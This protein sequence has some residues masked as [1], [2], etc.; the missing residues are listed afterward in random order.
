[1]DTMHCQTDN[2]IPNFIWKCKVP[3]IAKNLKNDKTQGIAL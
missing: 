1:M 2:L 3:R